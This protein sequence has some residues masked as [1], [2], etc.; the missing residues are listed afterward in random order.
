MHQGIEKIEPKSSAWHR[1]SMI[2]FVHGFQRGATTNDIRGTDAEKP[3]FVLDMRARARL[4]HAGISANAA[5]SSRRTYLRYR[6]K[7][8][9]ADRLK[10]ADELRLP[11]EY[12]GTGTPLQG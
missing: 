3:S 7:G 10:A 2:A 6:S 5:G 4:R 8:W 11:L 12:N 9:I 1:I